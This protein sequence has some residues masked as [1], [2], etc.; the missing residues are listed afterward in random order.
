MTKSRN[1]IIIIIPATKCFIITS[2]VR[3]RL[4]LNKLVCSKRD[5]DKI[6]SPGSFSN[7]I[8]AT[9]QEGGLT[10]LM[11]RQNID[12][13]AAL[14]KP[15][16]RG[17]RRE[18]GQGSSNRRSARVKWKSLW[19]GKLGERWQRANSIGKH[20]GLGQSRARDDDHVLTRFLSNIEDVDSTERTTTRPLIMGNDQSFLLD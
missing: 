11:A 7:Q 8:Y 16:G 10:I 17:H 3:I 9:I 1:S 19:E 18:G 14:G 2:K 15:P 5:Y 4:M 6:R 20:G 12:T 13:L